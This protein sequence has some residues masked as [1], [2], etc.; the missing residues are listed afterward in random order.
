VLYG[1][2]VAL[3]DRLRYSGTNNE[4]WWSRKEEDFPNFS[5]LTLTTHPTRLNL[6]LDAHMKT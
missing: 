6:A 1:V 5:F 3:D 4:D 2:T